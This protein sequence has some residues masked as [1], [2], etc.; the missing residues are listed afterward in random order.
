MLGIQLLVIGHRTEATWNN[1]SAT[2]KGRNSSGRIAFKGGWGGRRSCFTYHHLGRLESQ[3]P[4]RW[5]I[6]CCWFIHWFYL[7]KG[8]DWV[9]LVFHLNPAIMRQLLIDLL[10]AGR[11]LGT[12]LLFDFSWLRLSSFE[13][14]V[15]RS[16]I[17]LDPSGFPLQNV[18]HGRTVELRRNSPNYV[19][20]LAPVMGG[21][22]HV[23]PIINILSSSMKT[24]ESSSEDT[25]KLTK[26]TQVKLIFVPFFFLRNK[27]NWSRPSRGTAP[28]S[29]ADKPTNTWR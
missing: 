7:K 8:F 11:W 20:R 21:V 2:R 3:L 16:P 25:L 23:I 26:Q 5:N 6:L 27:W 9:A 12:R 14:F 10:T 24:N 29:A 28:E 22:N 19:E 17:S 4:S 1:Q 18:L 15:D 13:R